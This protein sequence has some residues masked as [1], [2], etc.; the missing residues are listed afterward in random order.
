MIR[1]GK[2]LDVDGVWKVSQLFPHLQ[3]LIAK[4]QDLFNKTYNDETMTLFADNGPAGLFIRLP[5]EIDS[6]QYI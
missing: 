3:S 2:S 1:T 6:T 4:Y 5:E